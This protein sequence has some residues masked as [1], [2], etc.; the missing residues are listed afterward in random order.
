LAWT[1]YFPLTIIAR[2]RDWL[3]SLDLEQRLSRYEIIEKVLPN[4]TPEHLKD[5]GYGD[6]IGLV[7]TH[8]KAKAA[9]AIMAEFD[10]ALGR[11]K[12]QFKSP[13]LAA[14]GREGAVFSI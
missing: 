10:N 5:P 13:C 4:L 14:A 1:G 8:A 3:R 2:T 9:L 12:R 11:R 7:R 6:A